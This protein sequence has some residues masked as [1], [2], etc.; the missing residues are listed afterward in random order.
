MKSLLLAF[1]ISVSSYCQTVNVNNITL[2]HGSTKHITTLT[3]PQSAVT[4]KSIQ[5][6]VEITISRSYSLSV[7]QNNVSYYFRFVGYKFGSTSGFE[8]ESAIKTQYVIKNKSYVFEF[9]DL[10]AD[11]YI[12]EVRSI[13]NKVVI[14]TKN[15]LIKLDN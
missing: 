4:T 3:I 15:I 13:Q 1:L 10:P 7:N 2:S 5:H 12:I 14:S 8:Y 6:Q 11:E 9:T